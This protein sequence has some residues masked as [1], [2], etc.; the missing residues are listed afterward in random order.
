ML[1]KTRHRA[2]A[3]LHKNP[4]IKKPLNNFLGTKEAKVKPECKEF[5]IYFFTLKNY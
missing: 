4:L 1:A 5:G 2:V 3:D